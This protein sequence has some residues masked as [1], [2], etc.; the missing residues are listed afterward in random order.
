MQLD[1]ITPTGSIFSGAVKS[2]QL[3][4]VDGSF[5]I[6]NN[7]APLIAALGEGKVKITTQDQMNPKIIMV[8]DGFVEVLNN[9]ITVLVEGIVT[10]QQ[11]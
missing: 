8:K 4:G 5:G 3:P 9:H 7:H 10:E 11:G 2:V 6:L 1:I